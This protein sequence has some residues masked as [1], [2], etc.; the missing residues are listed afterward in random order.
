MISK[1]LVFWL[2]FLFSCSSFG[3]PELIKSNINRDL[4]LISSEQK[5]KIWDLEDIADEKGFKEIRSI[6]AFIPKEG[7]ENY[8]LERKLIVGSINERTKAVK[9]WPLTPWAYRSK[10]QGE[11]TNWEVQK[12][13][14]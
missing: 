3:Q 11:G 13:L 5:N 6:I 8:F 4:D 14:Q 7:G 10:M 2:G 12:G 1:Y 9:A